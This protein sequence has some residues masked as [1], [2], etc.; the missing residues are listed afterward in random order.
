MFVGEIA[1]VGKGIF[2]GA[3]GTA[4]MTASSTIEARLRQRQASAAPVAAASTVLGIGP[5]GDQEK[6]RLSTLVHWGYG[7][8]WGAVGLGLTEL[9]T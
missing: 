1:A 9:P 6:A 5:W 7:T 8:A 2:A 4:A 3:A